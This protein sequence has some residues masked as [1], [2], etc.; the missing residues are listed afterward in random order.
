[1]KLVQ[2]QASKCKSDLRAL[3]NHSGVEKVFFNHKGAQA[4]KNSPGGY[5]S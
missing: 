4:L 1:L 3:F 5:F 2:I